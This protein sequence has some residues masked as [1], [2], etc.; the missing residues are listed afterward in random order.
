MQWTT[1]LK[2][3]RIKNTQVVIHG[4]PQFTNS[5]I[6]PTLLRKNSWCFRGF[7]LVTESNKVTHLSFW[8]GV[9]GYLFPF[10]SILCCV[11]WFYPLIISF[12]KPLFEF[13]P[14]NWIWYHATAHSVKNWLSSN[15]AKNLLLDPMKKLSLEEVKAAKTPLTLGVHISR[16]VVPSKCIIQQKVACYL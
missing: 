5:Y 12:F 6:V 15:T 10:P 1:S 2:Y 11:L 4:T 7:N 16:H 9:W 3:M 13:Y 14:S 8:H